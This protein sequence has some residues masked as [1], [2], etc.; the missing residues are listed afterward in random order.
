M[1]GMTLDIGAL[2]A[3]ER[4]DRRF[5]VWWKWQTSRGLVASVPSPVIAQA[6]RSTRDVRVAMVLAGCREVAMDASSSRRR[7]QRCAA[8][9][10]ADIVD[11][12]VVRGAADRRRRNDRLLAPAPR[13]RPPWPAGWPSSSG[14]P[15]VGEREQWRTYGVREPSHGVCEGDGPIH[16]LVLHHGRPL[17][18]PLA[19][20]Q[21]LADVVQHACVPSR[22]APLERRA[23]RLR[24]RTPRRSAAPQ[25][26]PRPSPRWSPSRRRNRR[27]HGRRVWRECDQR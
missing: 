3:A 24:R 16:P 14:L 27:S 2:I 9:K 20:A 11:A 7:G 22:A 8:A 21:R 1:A 6:W 26:G 4:N 25:T 19:P 10:T 23:H 17:G 12:F 5:W 15:A 18:L 13:R